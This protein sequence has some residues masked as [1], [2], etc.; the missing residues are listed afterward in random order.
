[1]TDAALDVVDQVDG[2]VLAVRA[3]PGAKRDAIV[4]LH[5]GA[6]KIAVTAPPEKGRANEA[7][8]EVL[9]DALSIARSRIE[10]RSGATSR[11]KKFFVEG[12]TADRLSEILMALVSRTR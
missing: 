4:G 6:L 11:Q 3:Q 9:A 8:V 12:I 1:M 7:I 10:L 2:A 5:A